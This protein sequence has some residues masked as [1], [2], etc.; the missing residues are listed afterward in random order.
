ME[1]FAE[2]VGGG[3]VLSKPRIPAGVSG[4]A[5]LVLDWVASEAVRVRAIVISA[6]EAIDAV[7]ARRGLEALFDPLDLPSAG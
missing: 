6:S 3:T 2:A 7:V 5:P 1:G 4:L